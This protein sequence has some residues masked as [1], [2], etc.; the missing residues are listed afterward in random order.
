MSVED[1]SAHRSGD[2]LLVDHRRKSGLQ[3][4]NYFD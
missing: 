3:F 1:M 2:R 4:F